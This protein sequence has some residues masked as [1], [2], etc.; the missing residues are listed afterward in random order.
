MSQSQKIDPRHQE[1]KKAVKYLFAYSFDKIVGRKSA[2]PSDLLAKKV[3]GKIKSINQAIVK[4]APKWPLEK[5][6]RVDL[7]ILRLAVW[8]LLYRSKVPPKVIINEAIELGKEYGGESSP[9]F[10][11]GALGTVYKDL[12]SK[13]EKN[14]KS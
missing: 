5:I 14:G 7:A 13:K 2:R 8:E 10:I 12:A 9:G 3:I 4:S 11:N 1:R 6:N